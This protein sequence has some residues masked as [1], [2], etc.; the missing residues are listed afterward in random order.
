MPE[1]DSM[2]RTI[3]ARRRGNRLGFWFFRTALRWTGLGGAYGLLYPVCLYYLLCDRAAVRVALSYVR[4]R[5]PGRGWIHRPLAVYRLFV[6]QGRNLIDRYALLSGEVPFQIEV[7]GRETL[8]SL[9]EDR[10]AG[11]IL[12]MS[13]VGNWQAILPTLRHLRRTVH[14]IMRPEDN[15]AVRKTLAVDQESPNVRV[16][17]P[18]QFLGGVLDALRALAEGHVV[19]VMGDRGYDFSTMEVQFLG[20]PARFPYAAF[21]LAAA[22]AC[23]VAVLF[24][25]PG[26]RRTYRIC[27]ARVFR[28]RY[29][30]KPSRREQLRAWV[31]EYATVVEAFLQEHPW[32][33]FLFHDVWTD[34][35][36]AYQR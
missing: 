5:F 36:A 15:W 7:E 14:L 22:A 9:L 19:A 20:S 21:T 10:S 31:Q 13:H 25:V 12:L 6:S 33:G 3:P 17:S 16:I 24:A 8:E 23:P 26:G 1:S 4:R 2:T 30:E 29:E 27:V 35:S 11:L 28:P 18:E 32:Q 34:S